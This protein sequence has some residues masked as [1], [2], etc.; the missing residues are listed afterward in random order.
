MEISQLESDKDRD[1]E[2]CTS[3]AAPESECAC[4]YVIRHDT[5]PENEDVGFLLAVCPPRLI[6]GGP[7]YARPSC[8]WI[9]VKG[10]GALSLRFLEKWSK[11][12]QLTLPKFEGCVLGLPPTLWYV[13][14]HR[15]HSGKSSGS[16]TLRQVETCRLL[17]ARV[18]PTQ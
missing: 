10:E 5:V 11:V 18:R 14:A 12:E 17:S 2:W 1:L 16:P 13:Y 6:E 15:Y 4:W 9:F 8:L 7:T 3:T